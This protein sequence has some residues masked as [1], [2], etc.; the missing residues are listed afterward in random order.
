MLVR[1]SKD[2]S[3]F[4]SRAHQR[5]PGRTLGGI[6]DLEYELFE[7]WAVDLLR[8]VG[9]FGSLLRRKPDSIHKSIPPFCPKS[10]SMYQ[11]FGK[12]ETKS[13]C[14]TGLSAET[15]DDS[16]ARIPVG[17]GAG[18][19][20][21]S[22]TAAGLQ[23]AILASSGSVF[24]HDSS[25]F[26][27]STASPIIHGER[28]DRMQLNNTATLLATYGYRTTK[29][30]E[31][32]TGKCKVSV[33]SIES[34]TRPLAIL[35]ANDNSTVFIGTDDRRLRSLNLEETQPTWQIVAQFDEEELEGHF[36]NSATH[37][38]LSKDGSMV[39]VAYRSHP[40][41]AWEADG[42][43]HIG[44]C[45]RKDEGVAIRELRE[46]V[47]HPHIPEILG[48][49][50]EGV[51]FKWAPYDGEIDELPVTATRLSISRD[52][53]LFATGDGHGKVKLYTTSTFTLLYQLAS[54]DAVFGLT[55]SPD[56]KRF[57]DIRG[58]YANAWEPNALL[59]FADQSSKD[60]STGETESLAQSSE[61]SVAISGAVHSITALAG[62]PKGRLYCCGTERGVVSLH[63]T[64]HGKLAEIYVSKAKFTIEKVTWSSDGNYICFTD[65]SKQITVMSVTP[66]VGETE[67]V[68]EQKAVIPMRK[69]AKGPILQLMF[70]PDSSHI[71]VHTSSRIC[72]I[73]LASFA[74]EQSPVLETTQ[75]QWIV[76]PREPAVILGFGQHT[77]YVFDW[78][79]TELQR[80]K[81]SWPADD[82]N[83]SS[84][85]RA[86]DSDGYQFDRILISDSKKHIFLQI[87]H[88]SDNS[89]GKKLF[90]LETSAISSV[91]RQESLPNPQE[92]D[93][94]GL[95]SI[96]PRALAADLSSKVALALSVLSKDRLVFLS[97]SF[98]I[99]SVQ[100]LWGAGPLSPR[101]VPRPT[102]TAATTARNSVEDSVG[103]RIQEL[104]SLP[105]DWISRDCLLVCS[106]WGVER[107]LL[108]PRNGEA[109]VVRCAGL[110]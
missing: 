70:Q 93:S 64:H 65:T 99:C 72:T 55:F 10:S 47:W 80:Y 74:V 25:D 5:D 104:F 67:P 105:G 89:R 57:Y 49:N 44:H 98:A 68:V 90:Y 66:A 76:H 36:M 84:A 24:L 23:I 54:Q 28:V 3:K 78:N 6:A 85:G 18:T 1:T 60:I 101:Q 12:S 83:D 33:E 62:S 34:K 35:F 52:G 43:S 19:F 46:L 27:E 59:R 69:F 103:D 14:V 63:S 7:S 95:S 37:V 50:V 100:P 45:W 109:A 42:P 22:I 106:I 8:N 15:W 51:V 110:A 21:S 88:T 17:H 86:Q 102:P 11:L 31:V 41:S 107:S 75:I 16:L 26:S 81:I 91:G 30:W 108:C 40:L 9:K 92:R 32:S 77:I 56:S 39:A 79:L 2:L 71:L 58:Y 53:E 61:A 29:V 4:A 97:K 13:L 96:S 20:A 94:S 87:S 38:A 82:F 48:L 73:S